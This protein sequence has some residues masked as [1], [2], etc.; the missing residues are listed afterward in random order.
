MSQKIDQS[1]QSGTDYERVADE[2]RRDLVQGIHSPGQR[3]KIAE[4]VERYHCGPGAVREVLQQL[5]GEG[6][7]D[8]QP[9]K[10]A[11]VRRITSDS[12]RDMYEVREYLEVLTAYRFVDNASNR[13][14]QN[15]E[16]IQAEFDRAAAQENQILCAGINKDFHLAV[17]TVAGNS[18]ALTVILRL[19]RMMSAIRQ[20]VGFSL[21]RLDTISAEHHQILAAFRDRDAEAAEKIIHVHL[22]GAAID[23]IE[24]YEESA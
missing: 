5:S 15:L 23:L 17:N 16:A 4:L 11:N 13:D 6:W 2:L 14:I 24:R 9:N 18:E 21:S 1:Q 19:G 20:S 12:I 3:L 22:S 8:I 7:V 10:G